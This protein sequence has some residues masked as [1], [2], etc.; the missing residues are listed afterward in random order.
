MAQTWSTRIV[1]HK[2]IMH[3]YTLHTVIP[4]LL[5]QILC[6]RSVKIGARYIKDNRS[7]GVIRVEM[8]PCIMQNNH[9]PVTQ[10]KKNISTNYVVHF[11]AN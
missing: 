5:R 11:V 1:Y 9:I 7:N 10:G 4:L 6:S 8:R 3:S 2:S